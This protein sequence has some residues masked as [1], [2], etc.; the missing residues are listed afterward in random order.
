MKALE[1]KG[2]TLP[3]I[4]IAV[5]IITIL[6]GMALPGIIRAKHN[7]NE[8][9]AQQTL[10]TLSTA[11]EMYYSDYSDYPDEDVI[12]GAL[13]DYLPNTAILEATTGNGKVYRGYH[14]NYAKL[15]YSQYTYTATPV[16]GGNSGTAQFIVDESGYVRRYDPTPASGGGDIAGNRGGPPVVFPSPP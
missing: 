3:E 7:A 14:F 2:F 5:A 12:A 1:N 13:F 8:A 6:A 16:T 4:M 15:G 11:L 10:R 9:L